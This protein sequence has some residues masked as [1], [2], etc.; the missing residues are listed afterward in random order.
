M[1][2][3]ER[4][5]QNLIGVHPDLVAVVARAAEITQVDFVVTEGV[6][7]LARQ[8][9]LFKR[10]ASQT[11]KSRHLK[12]V[13]FGHAVDLAAIVDGQISW[14]MPLYAWLWDAMATAA[15]ELGISVEWGGN[16]KTLRDGPHFQLPWAEYPA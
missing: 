4:S 3:N 9:E 13:E 11:M 5:T 16:W 2:L 14:D 10:G 8:R 7:S 12:A 1:E 15:E 6:R